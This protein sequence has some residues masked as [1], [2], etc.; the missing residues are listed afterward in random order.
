MHGLNDGLKIVRMYMSHPPVGPASFGHRVAEHVANVIA[1]PGDAGNLLIF[2]SEREKDR[3]IGGDDMLQALLGCKQLFFR[4]LP[5]SN[6]T[7]K[8]A[9]GK[10][11]VHADW[12]NHKFYRKL[13]SVAAHGAKFEE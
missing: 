5:L 6:I 8:S 2:D 1:H 10:G 12:P 7:Y 3:R 9:D 13:G 11:P 4:P